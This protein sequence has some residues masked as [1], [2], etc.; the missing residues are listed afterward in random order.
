MLF[1]FPANTGSVSCISVVCW[2]TGL[3]E[4]GH[5]SRNLCLTLG[6]SLLDSVLRLAP[7]A[8]VLIPDSFS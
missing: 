6:S 2:H 8:G 3:L 1:K 4:P 7:T 5:E